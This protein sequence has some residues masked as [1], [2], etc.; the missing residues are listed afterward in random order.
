VVE[1]KKNEQKYFT[2]SE[3]KKFDG[4]DGKPAYLAF[5]GKVYDVSSSYLWPT[6]VHV[7]SHNA[8][9]DLTTSIANAPHGEEVFA[10]FSVVGDI[11]AEEQVRGKFVGRLQKLH[12]HPMVVHF[13]ITI[14]ILA[15]LL[16]ILYVLTGD[17]SIEWVSWF[18]LLLGLLAFIVGGLTGIFSWKVTYEGR[19]TRMIARKIFLTVIAV[20]ITS[21][22]LVWRSLDPNVLIIKTN[23]SN[24]YLVLVASLVPIN[25]LLGHYGGKLV[26]P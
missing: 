10:N 26:Y 6:G 16:C 9:L 18:M 23:F 24:V 4:K 5:K 2:V 7:D 12:L 22:C 17:T 13:S 3:L 14:P 19:T 15:P 8:G 11:V 25:T 21:A 20:A 1:M